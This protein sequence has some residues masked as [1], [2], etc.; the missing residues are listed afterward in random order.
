MKAVGRKTAYS[1]M[2]VL[3]REPEGAEFPGFVVEFSRSRVRVRGVDGGWYS[4]PVSG[5]KLFRRTV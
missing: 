3:V 4:Y 2:P 1:G 5:V